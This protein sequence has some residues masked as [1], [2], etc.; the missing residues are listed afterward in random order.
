MEIAIFYGNPGCRD[1]SVDNGNIVS[2]KITMAVNN[3]K[4][5]QLI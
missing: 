4:N 1:Q 3:G 2:L 5:R